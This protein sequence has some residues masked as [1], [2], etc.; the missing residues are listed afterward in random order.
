MNSFGVLFN[1][2][3]KILTRNIEQKGFVVV[4]HQLNDHSSLFTEIFQT[5]NSHDIWSVL[6][7]RIIAKFVGYH[8]ARGSLVCP[9]PLQIKDIH[10]WPPGIKKN[11]SVRLRTPA[12]Q[13]AIGEQQWV[14]WFHCVW[15]VVGW[16]IVYQ[17]SI[18]SL[19]CSQYSQTIC[20][21]G[22]DDNACLGV[23][24]TE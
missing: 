15:S 9:N 3:S 11:V 20:L 18:L 8:Q 23:R 6:S 10:H 17:L 14:T 13:S 5:D 19:S 16:L 7:I 1:V 2:K 22:W 21:S 24:N 4:L 12:V